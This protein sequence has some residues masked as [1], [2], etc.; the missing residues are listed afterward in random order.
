ML[1]TKLIGQS[2]AHL[3]IVIIII[4]IVAEDRI[5]LNSLSLKVPEQRF[6]NLNKKC[7]GQ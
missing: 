2:Y 7:K 6:L 3:L 1:V 4:V 5:E